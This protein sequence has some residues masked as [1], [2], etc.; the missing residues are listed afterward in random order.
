MV[1]SQLDI[2][3][4]VTRMPLLLLPTAAASK[5]FANVGRHWDA[6]STH[7]FISGYLHA[8][9]YTTSVFWLALATVYWGNCNTSRTELDNIAHV[10]N[11][12]HWLNAIR[13]RIE[14]PKPSSWSSCLHG[15]A[16]SCRHV[17]RIVSTS[18]HFSRRPTSIQSG[19]RGTRTSIGSRCC[20]IVGPVIRTVHLLRCGRSICLLCVVC[21]AIEDVSLQ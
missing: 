17:V 5:I 7:A 3:D 20:A 13:Q 16:P 14:F 1:L 18:V 15:L 8:M 21:Q 19:T 10:L 4:H 6:R 2:S 9:D 12:L 11:D